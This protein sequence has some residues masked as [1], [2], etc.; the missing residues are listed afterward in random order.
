MKYPYSSATL[1]LA[2]VLISLPVVAAVEDAT[3]I[4][5]VVVTATRTAE[6]ADQTLAPVTVVD[7]DEIERR[8]SLTTVDILRGLPGVAI[9]NSG[10]PG[11]QTDLFLRGTN[12][13][14]TLF[15]VDGIKIGSA[16]TGQSAFQNIPVEQ[17]ERV[18]VVRGPR[19]SL[20]G[21]EAAGGVIQIFTRRGGGPLRPFF[22]TLAGRYGTAGVSG[23]LS[24]GGERGR[25]SV[26]AN[27]DQTEGFNACNGIGFP[28][29]AGCA[30]DEPDQ[31]GYTNQGVSAS[32]G[33]D[34][35]DR[36]RLDV[37]FLNSESD[38]QFDG[39]FTNESN[40]K[41]QVIG[42]KLDLRPLENWDMTLSAGRS[43]DDQDNFK[44]G[45]FYSTFDTRR[46][47]LGWQNNIAIGD[48]HLVTLGVDYQQ[49]KVTSTTDYDVDTRDD[50]GVYG[51]YQGWFGPGSVKAS[52]RNDDN[53][54]FGNYVTGDVALGWDVLPSLRLVGTYGTAFTAP[55]FND[56]YF[57]ADPFFAGGN[58][59]LKPE[60]TRSAELGVS[61]QID[62]L[63]SPLSDPWQWSLNLYQT[64]IDDLIA[65]QPPLFSAENIDSARIRGL[66][67]VL[68]GRLLGTDVSANLTL[69]DPRNKSD[70]LDNGNLL[71]RRP[72]QTFRLDIDRG[73]GRFAAGGTVFVAGRRYNDPAN[74]V[75]IS[76]F[77]L[78]DLRVSYAFSD[79]LR[80]QGR[81]E[82]ALDEDYETVTWY[83]QP[84]RAFYLTLRYQP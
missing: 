84:G 72:Q 65:L 18:E 64:D 13:N 46:D 63:S 33:Y 44:D 53:E 14:Q 75:P 66:E 38:V 29:F 43:L 30:T 80:I 35:S 23:G 81:L 79:A 71:A 3:Q 70:G 5:P 15:L 36:I 34:F 8:Q 62:A 78:L 55:T 9:S 32:A 49:D 50:V 4:D 56:L 69:L 21:S 60:Q 16:T 45:R 40:S 17:I 7:R 22:S 47:T 57:P 59:D 52:L 12:S 61:G 37:N 31:D 19:S 68:L 26:S 10:G 58:P 74:E 77:T 42:A 25:F 67:A 39:A 54:Q 6:T 1:L 28:V 41:Q 11:R 73:F 27:F 76:G 2:L 83:N 24:G 51:Q 20:Y 82:N 48:Q